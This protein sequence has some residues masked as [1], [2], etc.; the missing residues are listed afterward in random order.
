MATEPIPKERNSV[1]ICAIHKK[2]YKLACDNYIGISLYAH[3]T[4]YLQTY[5]N[6]ELL[7]PMLKTSEDNR[8]SEKEDLHSIFTIHQNNGENI[9]VRCQQLQNIT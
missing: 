2:G 4:K 6:K 7:S 5:Y 8:A 9:G 3:P 1:L